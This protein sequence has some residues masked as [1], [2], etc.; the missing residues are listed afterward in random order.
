MPH[1]T[2]PVFRDAP[3][4][5]Q[6]TLKSGTI[7]SLTMILTSPGTLS[8]FT[9]TLAGE[10]RSG[11]YKHPN[12]VTETLLL[13][14]RDR[15]QKLDH[16]A[17]CL[18][19]PAMPD[20]LWEYRILCDMLQVWIVCGFSTESI[21]RTARTDRDSLRPRITFLVTESRSILA[22]IKR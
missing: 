17:M 1:Y 22:L 19:P 18:W 11:Q 9:W 7:D 10:N 21:L 2:T 14:L 15:Q 3:S 6:G 4:V 16:V 13:S 12:H 5:V 20:H 8:S